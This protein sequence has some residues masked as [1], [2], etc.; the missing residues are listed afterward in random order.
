MHHK[1]RFEV[2][3]SVLVVEEI[4]AGDAKAAQN[5]LNAVKGIS[6]A[7]ITVEAENIAKQTVKVL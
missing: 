7:D 6:S 4:S 1:Q 2:F 3:I 5:R